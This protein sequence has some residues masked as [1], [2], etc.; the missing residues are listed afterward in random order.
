MWGFLC[1]GESMTIRYDENKIKRPMEEHEYTPEQIREL[2]ECSGDVMKFLK[3]IRIINVDDGEIPFKP[4]DYQKEFIELVDK[5]RFTIGLWTR[6]SG[7][8]TLVC[9][10]AL[11]FAIFN[12]DK[13]INIVS[14]KEKSAKK[15]LR[16][17]KK[18]YECLPAWIKPGAERYA[19]TMVFFDNGTS[20]EISATSDDAFRGDS[21]NLLIM[22]EFAFVPKGQADA[23][24]S[25][26]YPTISSS[27]KAK[28][29][30]ISTPNGMYNLFHKLWLGAEKGTN[31]FNPM[32]VSYNK[33]PGR[34]EEWAAQEKANIGETRFRQEFSC[35]SGNTIITLRDEYTGEIINIPIEE[36][37]N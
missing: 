10:Y 15:L 30:I 21:S 34:D 13:V 14:N 28:I 22:D 35:V 6:Q 37:K 31:S 36:F 25:S 2:S 1:Y 3:H 23:F 7:K 29:I 12:S 17:L 27:K 11:W 24:W 26:N 9:A 5:N 16:R 32:K 19:E 8:S 4:Y 18:M 33:V 20:I